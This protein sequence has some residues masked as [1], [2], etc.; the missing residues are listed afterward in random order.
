VAL[1][2]LGRATVLFFRLRFSA[3]F[4][5]PL[6]P[7]WQDDP[8]IR[9]VFFL[10]EGTIALLAA[11]VCEPRRLLRQ[12]PLL[13]FLVIAGLSTT[14][15]V[16]PNVT[17]LRVMGFVGASAVGYY[18]GARFSIRDQA[19]AVAGTAAVGAGASVLALI[20][21]PDIARATDWHHDQWSGVYVNRNLLAIVL[22]LGLLSL[23]IVASRLRGLRLLAVSALACTELYLF[24]RTGNRTGVVALTAGAGAVALVAGLRTTIR[25]GLSVR[26]GALAALGI[27]AAAG[28]L[29]SLNWTTIVHG[30]G[31]NTT[32]SARTAMWTIDHQ[33]LDARPWRGWG[34]EALWTHGPTIQEAA[35]KFHY[36]PLQAH[37]GYLEILLG[38]G[39]LGFGVFSLYLVVTLYRT[40]A[41]AWPVG[42]LEDLWPLALVVFILVSNASESFFIA[43]EAM[44]ALLV[45]A[46]VSVDRHSPGRSR[47]AH[48]RG[49]RESTRRY[50]AVNFRAAS[51]QV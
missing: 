43:N 6:A 34:F 42:T 23:P 31:R 18:L 28:Y 22:A 21:W 35:A 10:T 44:W 50:T 36:A 29:V 49:G 17:Q 8:V 9:T 27:S 12:W 38:V 40:F 30:L 4:G 39:W 2:V 26:T 24:W 7:F 1:F 46:G 15:S 20:V 14:W 5:G 13:V 47:R 19:R 25:W 37:N 16:E 33:L 51:D 3:H 11:R 41:H 48:R 32:L 45:A